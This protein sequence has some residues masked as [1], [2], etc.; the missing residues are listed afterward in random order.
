MRKNSPS[1]C[2]VLYKLGN[3][4]GHI[5][6]RDSVLYYVGP[7]AFALSSHVTSLRSQ[8]T[9]SSPLAT[10]SLRYEDVAL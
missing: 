4:H 6:S 2:G 7:T 9:H 3:L 8:I 5:V 1:V 10:N